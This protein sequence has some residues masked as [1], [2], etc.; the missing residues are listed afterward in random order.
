M[1]QKSKRFDDRA[2]KLHRLL[3]IL[4]MIDNRTRCTPKTLAEKFNISIR[5]IER[6]ITD[7][8]SAGFAIAF[9]KEEDTFRFADPDYTLRDLDLNKNELTFLLIGRQFAHNLGKPFEKA[10]QSLLKKAHKDTGIKTR[11]RIKEIEEKP[12]FWVDMDQMEEFEKVEE[13]YNAINEAMDRKQEIEILYKAMK[14]QEE[15]RRSIAPYGLFF[16]EGL[17]Y[18]IGY[19]RLRDEIRIFALDCIKEIKVTNVP[20]AI[21]DNFDINEYFKPGWKMRRYGE[22]VEVVLKF[23]ERYAR[24]I[25]RKKWH[26]TQVI[27]EQK[28]GSIVFK[29]KVEGTIELKWWIYHWIPHVEVLSPPELKQEMIE[30]MEGMLKVYEKDV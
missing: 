15:T 22:P 23:S 28:D 24:W 8:S 30:E 16:H 10:C 6:D 9:V 20:Y 29:V 12:H 18:V 25:K 5:T 26:P 2:K 27:E 17:W 1:K 13:Q 19:C 3:A 7:L 21:P 11:E 14:N 4:R